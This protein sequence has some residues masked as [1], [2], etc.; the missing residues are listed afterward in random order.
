[1]PHMTALI[2]SGGDDEQQVVTN[3]SRV[4]SFLLRNG[5]YDWSRDQAGVSFLQS[6][7]D[8][9]VPY[10][11]FFINAAPSHIAN[12][13][14]SC[15]WN[16][17][18]NQT[19]A[20]ADYMTT[21]LSHWTD[22]GIDIKYISPMN[23]PDN[24]RSDCGQEGMA[25]APAYRSAIFNTL[26]DKLDQSSAAGV[27]IIADE[28]SRVIEQGVPEDP[29]W[30]PQSTGS[31]SN[32]AIHDYD[33]VSDAELGLYYQS[34]LNLTGGNV[35]PI[36]FTEICCSVNAANGPSAFGSQNDPT[37]ANALIVARYIWQFLTITNAQ[38]F[39]WWTAV[40]GLPCSP[41]VDGPQCATG[42]NNTAGYNSGLIYIDGAY[43]TTKDYTLYPTKRAF[44][45][46]HF[47]YFHRPGSVRYDIPADT[48]PYGVNAFA[49]KNGEDTIKRTLMDER[50]W[51]DTW[52]VLLFNNQTSSFNMSLEAPSAISTLYQ[53][54]KTDAEADWEEV[55]PMP[56]VTNGMV[57]FELPA[58]SL[59]S[60][61]FCAE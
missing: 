5:T 14:A 36:K 10:I 12:N 56:E 23:E 21:V 4:E 57:T 44:M 28:T 24:N 51:K 15:G 2:S 29:A 47:S 31:I 17:T 37:M 40:A 19:D 34:V 16:F 1:M 46:K 27:D 58:E 18:A 11:T 59:Y 3:G 22:E 45:L 61:R 30:L 8:Y 42:I 53:V 39:D 32:I 55:D 7:Q 60:L 20:F 13:G 35:P 52:N 43:N 41:T 33:F 54:V 6:A 26:R 49:T 9:G 48:L 25:V 50:N 38:S